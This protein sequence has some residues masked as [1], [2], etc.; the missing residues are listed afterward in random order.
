[1]RFRMGWAWAWDFEVMLQS[2]A[3]TQPRPEEPIFSD[4]QFFAAT[5]KVEIGNGESASFWK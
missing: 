3:Q 1:M 5:A 2:S 4:Q